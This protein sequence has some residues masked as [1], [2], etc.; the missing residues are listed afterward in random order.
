MLKICIY[1]ICVAL[2]INLILTQNCE[3][4]QT[5]NAIYCDN[6]TS[7]YFCVAGSGPI[8]QLN[9]CPEG[10]ICTNTM[11]FCVPESSVNDDT[12]LDVCKESEEEIDN[13]NGIDCEICNGTDGTYACVSKTQYALCVNGSVTKSNVLDCATDEVCVLSAQTDYNNTCV[14]SC[15]LSFLNLE[16][17]CSNDVVVIPTVAP[18]NKDAMKT[19]CDG[20]DT[21]SLFFYTPYAEDTNCNGFIYCQRTS[22]QDTAWVVLYLTC[23]TPATPYYDSAKRI[24]VSTRPTNC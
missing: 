5:E 24:C 15:A 18:P 16:A 19:I 13:V 21:T 2:Q 7:Y 20:I 3:Q 6:R 23:P 1:F 22:V 9:I 8:G 14:P 17:T 11:D 12:I 10:Q 4:C